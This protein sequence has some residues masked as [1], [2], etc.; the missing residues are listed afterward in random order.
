MNLPSGRHDGG[1][2]YSDPR[3]THQQDPRFF[4]RLREKGGAEALERFRQ[5]MREAD[6]LSRLSPETLRVLRGE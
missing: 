4:E 1:A 5:E 3:P 6:E 2:R